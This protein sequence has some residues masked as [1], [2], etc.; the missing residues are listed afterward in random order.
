MFSPLDFLGEAREISPADTAG[1]RGARDQA[2]DIVM[3]RE[4]NPQLL[5]SSPEIIQLRS[6]IG[7]VAGSEAKVL[8][9]A[10]AGPARSSW[11]APST[12]KAFVQPGHSW[13]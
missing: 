8:L 7:R 1:R 9:P 13:P 6:E 10:R 4:T 3:P 11:P 2:A 5:G 12:P